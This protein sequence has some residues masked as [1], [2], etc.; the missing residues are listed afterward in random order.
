MPLNLVDATVSNFDNVFEKFRSEAQNNRANLIL[1]L[2]DKDPSTSLSW[3]PGNTL[4]SFFYIYFPWFCSHLLKTSLD[5]RLLM[6][7]FDDHALLSYLLVIA[8]LVMGLCCI[9]IIGITI[10]FVY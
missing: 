9:M 7:L 3:C 4:F 5:L 8:H 10:I 1:F 6:L 2:A